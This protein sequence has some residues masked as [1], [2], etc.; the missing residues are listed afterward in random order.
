MREESTEQTE[1]FVWINTSMEG[2][3]QSPVQQELNL[4]VF[5]RTVAC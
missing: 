1:I 5:K 2:E 3:S 4:Y